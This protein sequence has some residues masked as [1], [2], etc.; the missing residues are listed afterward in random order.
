MEFEDYHKCLQNVVSSFI[1]TYQKTHC[2]LVIVI[3][4]K[5]I[6]DSM[7]INVKMCDKVSII[8]YIRQEKLCHVHVV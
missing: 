7:K 1:K 3:E 5:L 8:N 4:E 6:L 2:T